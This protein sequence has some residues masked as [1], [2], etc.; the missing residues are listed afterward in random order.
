MR[1]LGVS[2]AQSGAAALHYV[3]PAAVLLFFV[4]SSSTS[5]AA[6]GSQG[7]SGT[8]RQPPPSGLLKWLFVLAIV[9]IVYRSRGIRCLS[10]RL[11]TALS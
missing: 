10:C 9:T 7:A 11:P 6:V 1:L 2:D 4:I 8:A 5:A 3:V